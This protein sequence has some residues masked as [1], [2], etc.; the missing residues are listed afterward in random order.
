MKRLYFVSI[1]FMTM[2]STIVNAQQFDASLQLR[3]RYEY[4]HGYKNFL[5]TNEKPA[6]LISQRT[7]LNFDFKTMIGS[8]F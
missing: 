4:R 2:K 6:S 7:K 8:F 1:V 5:Q 3:P